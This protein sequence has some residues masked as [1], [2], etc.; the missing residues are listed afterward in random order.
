MGCVCPPICPGART[1]LA[2]AGHDSGTGGNVPSAQWQPIARQ[3]IDPTMVSQMS[4]AVARMPGG[5][6]AGANALRF[7]GGIR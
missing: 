5:I 6:M 4:P 3:G 2:G 1:G 7:G